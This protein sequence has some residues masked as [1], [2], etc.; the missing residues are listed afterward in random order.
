M[1]SPLLCNRTISI[2]LKDIFLECRGMGLLP[3]LG[4]KLEFTIKLN[5]PSYCLRNGLNP[6]LPLSEIKLKTD[7]GYTLKNCVMAYRKLTI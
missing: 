7:L 5:S 6:M 3:L 4:N 1:V 2:K